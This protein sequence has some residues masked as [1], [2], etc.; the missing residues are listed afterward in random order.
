MTDPTGEFFAVVSR[1]GHTPLLAEVHGSIRFDLVSDRGTDSWFVDVRFGDLQVLHE[2]RE[3]DCVVRTRRVLF[4]RLITGQAN[5]YTAWLRNDLSIEGE[6]QLAR[7]LQRIAPGPPGAHHP[8][9]FAR[10][11]R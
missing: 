8:R 2:R 10:E 11:R 5:I 6:V 9:A 4:D 1:R 7:Y 3:A